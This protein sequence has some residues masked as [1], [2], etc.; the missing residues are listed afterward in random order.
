M[1]KIS[2]DLKELRILKNDLRTSFLV[3]H[4]KSLNY[5]LKATISEVTFNIARLIN[6]FE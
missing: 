3:L 1:K 6:F 2:K 4:T 5:D